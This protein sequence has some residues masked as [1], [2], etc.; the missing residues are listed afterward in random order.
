MDNLHTNSTEAILAAVK[1]LPLTELEQ[2]VDRM[3]AIRAERVAPHLTANESA[4]L[5]R[6]NQG[7]SME[8]RI[9]MRALIEKRDGESLSEEEW[10]ELTTLTDRLEVLHADRLAA[11]SE[12]GK[13]R[14]ISLQ[15]VL[16]Q[17]GIQLPDHD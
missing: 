6:I 3:I 2:L 13:L 1:Q 17:F 5:S 7:L 16:T 8:E 14:G 11:L 12:W 4:L 10:R 9:R 15:E